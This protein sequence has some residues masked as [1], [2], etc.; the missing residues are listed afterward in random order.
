[1]TGIA[2]VDV[3]V[4]IGIVGTGVALLWKAVAGLM[5]KVRRLSHFLDDWN[6]E[7][8]RPGVPYRPGF[9]ERVAVIEQELRPN[10][11]SSLRD[12]VDR[13]ERGVRRVEDGLTT[14]LEQHR[15]SAGPIVN[16][17]TT[18]ATDSY[19]GDGHQQGAAASE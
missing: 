8:A 15:L 19:A 9:P 3:F 10:H 16:V 1:M 14:H 18:Q 5:V 4:I 6:G 13:L 17:T 7:A 12:A 11:G 2:W